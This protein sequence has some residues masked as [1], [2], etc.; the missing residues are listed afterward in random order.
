M[1]KSD[2]LAA[3][4]RGRAQHA[5]STAEA[6]LLPQVRLKHESAASVWLDL[7][8]AQDQRTAHAKKVAARLL[9]QADLVRLAPTTGELA[10]T[11]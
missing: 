7:A 9:A 11:T 8:A 6:S 10:C 2:I 5:L 3:E 4:Y 1:L